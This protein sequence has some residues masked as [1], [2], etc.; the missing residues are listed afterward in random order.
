MSAT[1]TSTDHLIKLI[2]A[3][4]VQEVMEFIQNISNDAVEILNTIGKKGKLLLTSVS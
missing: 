3:N 2:E 4:K 1:E